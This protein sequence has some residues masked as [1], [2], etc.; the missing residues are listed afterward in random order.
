MGLESEN[1]TTTKPSVDM[2]STTPTTP[3]T[4][5]AANVIIVSRG[6]QQ[7]IVRSP[8][9]TSNNTT[10]PRPQHKRNPSAMSAVEEEKHIQIGIQHCHIEL[11]RQSSMRSTKE[12][13]KDDLHSRINH[14]Y[15]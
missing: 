13:S 3:T 5:T 14:L 4:P 10:T 12:I 11:L 2:T 8:S 7:Q 9:T 6:S 15:V 1:E